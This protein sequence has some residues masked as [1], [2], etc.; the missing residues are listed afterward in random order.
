MRF[1]TVGVV[2]IF[3]ILAVIVASELSK[4]EAEVATAQQP[5]GDAYN[6]SIAEPPK[7]PGAPDPDTAWVYRTDADPMTDGEVSQACT[8]SEEPVRLNFPYSPVYARLCLREHPR[9]GL[10][11]IVE[12]LGQGQIVCSSYQDCTVGVRFD[13][14]SVQQFS[15]AEP[16]DHSSNAIF[17][18]NAKRFETS[19][20]KADKT[21]IQ[22]EF[23]QAGTQTLSF[24]T[25]GLK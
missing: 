4:P 21:L 9:H 1:F 19:A 25:A 6:R 3:T 8:R 16:S 24:N 12:L 18:R 14:G 2:A 10:D 17:I 7:L 20:R 23:Y 22:L 13:K 11:V 5:S 15:A